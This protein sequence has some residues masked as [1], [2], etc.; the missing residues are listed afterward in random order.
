[1]VPLEKETN[2]DVLR[3]ISLRL[4]DQLDQTSHEFSKYK[5]DEA[6]TENS[7]SFPVSADLIYRYKMS[8][9]E[10][11]AESLIRGIA[12]GSN[13]WNE[14]GFIKKLNIKKNIFTRFTR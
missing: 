9:K 13:A 6:K 10:L 14:I 12:D 8:E 4:R 1:M 2:I 3:K 5:T 11:A 7:D